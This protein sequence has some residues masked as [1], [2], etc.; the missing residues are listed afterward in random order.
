MKNSVNFLSYL[1]EFFL[2]WEFFRTKVVEKIKTRILRSVALFQKK[3]K[4]V[5][6][7]RYV[8]KYCTAGKATDD[9]T[10]GRMRTACSLTK[11]TDTHTGYV[12]LTAFPLQQWLN[13]RTK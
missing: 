4:I 13:K 10:I 2:E 8:R 12:K 11:A 3:N 1:T 5:P 6:F 9:N 7:M